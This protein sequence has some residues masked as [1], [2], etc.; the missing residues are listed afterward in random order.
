MK[1]SYQWLLDFVDLDILG[2]EMR[3]LS[4]AL[5]MLG[6]AVEGVEEK[7]D[8]Y[9]FDVDVTTNRPDCLNH[10]GVARELAARFC[11][12]LKRPD[13]REPPPGVIE[14]HELPAAVTIE[15]SDDCP[16]YAARVI[17]GVRVEES[18][19]W[20]KSRLENLGQRPINNIVDIT[21]YVLFEIGHP[22]HAFDYEKLAGG[23][24][25]VRKARAGETL[26]TLDGIERSLDP[27]MLMICDA[28]KPVAVAGVMGGE[29]SEISPATETLLLESAYFN[30]AS[31][32]A[33]ARRLGLRTEASFRFERGADPDLPVRAL[34]LASSLIEK[35]AHGKC[36]GP[37]IDEHPLVRQ[38]IRLTLREERIRQVLGIDLEL[39]EASEILSRLEFEV[40]KREAGK[41][42]VL[43]PS[44]RSDIAIED[45]LVEEVARHYGYDRIHSTYPAPS[46][47]GRFSPGEKVQAIVDQVLTGL[48]FSEA[49]TYSFTTRERERELF[50]EHSSPIPIAN[51]LSEADTHLRTSLLPGLLASLRHNFN[52]GQ[53]DVRLYETG[54][55]F[56][57]P[58]HGM[59]EE[60]REE[61]R[62]A[63]AAAGGFYQ[64]YWDS[65]EH[66]FKFPHLKGV[67]EALFA[68]LRCPVEFSRLQ[69][70]P[71]LHPGKAARLTLRGRDL[72]I[73]GELHPGLRGRM[74][75]PS[76][77]F[78]LELSLDRLLGGSEVAFQYRPVSRFPAVERD[79][80]FLVDK[81]VEY[82]KLTSA[83]QALRIAELR[84]VELIDFYQGRHLPERKVSLTVRFTFAHSGRTLTQEEVNQYSDQIFSELRS[85]FSAEAR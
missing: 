44:F 56:L 75:L 9:I 80:S 43:S 29:N 4:D 55:V 15:E 40:L 71:F 77:V 7:G 54:K 60:V 83:V 50:G 35:L 19:P 17:T 12:K 49:Y 41:V 3:T 46:Q 2:V 52:H 48:G 37:V 64:P 8:D 30:P 65:F 33:T 42:Q 53:Q 6:L 68:Q 18:P 16:R 78:L 32:R 82:G 61:K 22:L 38:P 27:S 14:G 79:L 73:L 34:N 58:N 76:R 1:I 84:K 36:A 85:R 81:S 59:G 28:G 69:S 26:T 39:Q 24:I 70:S 25:I 51:P 63:L 45:D 66:Q 10:L 47:P 23:R 31:V 57:A 20:L 74:K 72:G 13:L 67:A 21:N 5:T 11:L 62:L